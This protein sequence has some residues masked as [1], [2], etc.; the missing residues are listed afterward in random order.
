MQDGV[1]RRPPL[2]P[3]N[4]GLGDVRGRV[5]E[6]VPI[7]LVRGARIHTAHPVVVAR[8][9]GIEPCADDGLGDCHALLLFE[10]AVLSG[11]RKMVESPVLEPALSGAGVG[12]LENSAPVGVDCADVVDDLVDDTVRR[13]VAL[14]DDVRDLHTVLFAVI[15][16]RGVAHVGN[17]ADDE[18]PV[19]GHRLQLVR[20]EGFGEDLAYPGLLL[21]IRYDGYLALNRPLALRHGGHVPVRGI[22]RVYALDVVD[23]RICPPIHDLLRGPTGGDRDLGPPFEVGPVADLLEPGNQRPVGN[24]SVLVHRYAVAVD[25][26]ADDHVIPII[27]LPRPHSASP[28]HQCTARANSLTEYVPSGILCASA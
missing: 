16:P 25:A 6:N 7:V 19:T 28:M 15:A 21:R 22:G 1:P 9:A 27:I 14:D 5:G 10:D 2:Q 18:G 24:P 3:R 12:R 8:L 20:G 13:G 26:P 23:A 11:L 4:L 17:G